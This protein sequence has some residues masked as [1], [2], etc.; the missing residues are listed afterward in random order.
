MKQENNL[1]PALL[2]EHD[3]DT[4]ALFDMIFEGQPHI[5]HHNTYFGLMFDQLIRVKTNPKSNKMVLQPVEPLT[6]SERKQVCLSLKAYFD[7]AE[8]FDTL[9]DITVRNEVIGSWDAPQGIT[10]S[11]YF[12][13]E[14]NQ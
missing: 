11:V 13:E 14:N 2:D 4:Q 8:E 10:V 7:V 9:E 12:K 5:Q 1:R 3:I 6:D